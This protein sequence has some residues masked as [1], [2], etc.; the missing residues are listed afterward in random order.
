MT[1]NFK[2]RSLVLY[3]NGPAIVDQP[4]D[5]IAIQLAGGKQIK[6]RPKDIQ[7]LHPGP[8]QSLAEL[9]QEPQGNMEDAWELLQGETVDLTELADLIYGAAT[10]ASVWHSWRLLDEAIHFTGT[11]EELT[12]RSEAEVAALLDKQREKEEEAARWE[13]YL[14]RVKDRAIQP[15]DFPHLGDLERLAYGQASTN[16][17]LKALGI[18]IAPEKAHRL[19]LQL[20]LWND[21]VNP[22]P[23]RFG[24]A[25][26]QPELQVPELPEEP[27]E[28]L[29]ALETFA[30]DD[31]NCSDPDDAI[32]LDG[33]GLWI[34]V[35][36]AA[37]L[38][39]ADSPLDVEARARGANL[40]LPE[41]VINMLPEDVTSIL[42]LGLQEISPALSFKIGV[43]ADGTPACLK[44]VPSWI[45]VQRLSYSAADQLMEIA[46][47]QQMS[48]ITEQFRARRVAQGAARIN[49][50]EV[51]LKTTV[52]GALYNLCARHELGFKAPVDFAVEIK[53]LPRLNSREM[54]TDAMLMA[55]EAIARYCLE[56]AI[57]VPF[58]CQ[59]PPD[60]AGSPE[61]M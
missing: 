30:I 24:C 6:V 25:T 28:D 5:K 43:G 40:Y 2:A 23:A 9:D 37:A 42:G 41:V 57:P 47:F 36:D 38:I 52:E 33:D 27:R 39:N 34:H 14:Q 49:L 15:E 45:R 8:L 58:A 51:K 3:K 50:P 12:P 16:R 44:I 22:Y 21:A 10:P 46:P 29:T 60:E 13:A 18:E 20:A 4:G 53:D 7:L 32:S 26:T 11:P 31:D 61:T 56:N 17:T 35:A 19:L 1:Q 55:G 54:V 48:V 59:P